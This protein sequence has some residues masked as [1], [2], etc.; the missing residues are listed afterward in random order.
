[1]SDPKRFIGRKSST[2]RK[3][4]GS[5]HYVN[6]IGGIVCVTCSPPKSPADDTFRLTIEGGVWIDPANRFDMIEAPTHGSGQ[7]QQPVPAGHPAVTSLRAA[8]QSSQPN[9]QQH[10]AAAGPTGSAN[11]FRTH[12]LSR[13]PGGEFS[14]AELRLF[15]SPLVWDQPGECVTLVGQRIRRVGPGLTPERNAGGGAKVSRV[16]FS[17]PPKIVGRQKSANGSAEELPFCST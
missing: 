9:G 1:M 10:P 3:C 17:G 7:N 14:E 2:C 15:G 4:G 13:G 16:P 5:S 11:E 8:G 6:R 12:W